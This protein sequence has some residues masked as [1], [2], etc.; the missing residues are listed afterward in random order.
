MKFVLGTVVTPEYQRKAGA[1][2]TLA[3]NFLENGLSANS[4]PAAL[5][6]AEM[7]TSQAVRARIAYSYQSYCSRPLA[8]PVYTRRLTRYTQSLD[9]YSKTPSLGLRFFADGLHENNVRLK[10]RTFKCR[11]AH[12]V[13]EDFYKVFFRDVEIG[14]FEVEALRFRPVQAWR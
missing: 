11:D 10:L 3:S 14:E 5:E 8:A 12:V 7:A 6:L 4:L 2:R 9:P 1:P 13:A